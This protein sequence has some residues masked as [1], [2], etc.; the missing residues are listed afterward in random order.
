MRDPRAR[1]DLLPR[2]N[3]RASLQCPALVPIDERSLPSGLKVQ[4]SMP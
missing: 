4:A 2:F 3:D 1:R